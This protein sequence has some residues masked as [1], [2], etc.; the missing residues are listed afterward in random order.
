MTFA[1][2]IVAVALGTF[3]GNVLRSI[4]LALSCYPKQYDKSVR[5]FLKNVQAVF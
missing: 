2:M 4:V 5:Q 3:M 1:E